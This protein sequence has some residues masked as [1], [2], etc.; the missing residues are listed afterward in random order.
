MV[1]DQTGS[2]TYTLDLARAVFSLI[3]NRAE[4]FFHFAGEGS[5]SWYE[6]A[7]FLLAAAGLKTPVLPIGSDDAGRRARR[8]SYSVLDCSRY[9]RLTGKPIRSWRE[10]AADYLATGDWRLT[11]QE[12]GEAVIRNQ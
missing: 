3:E 1:S 12:S 4:G 8:P 5:C 11:E 6:F 9:T 2:P 7:A 10:M